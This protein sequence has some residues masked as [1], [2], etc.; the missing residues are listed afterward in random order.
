M[1]TTLAQI[2]PCW[3]TSNHPA[4]S[5]IET[6]ASHPVDRVRSVTDEG[7]HCQTV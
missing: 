7:S 4:L 1:T 3:V 5:S 2:Q 6:A